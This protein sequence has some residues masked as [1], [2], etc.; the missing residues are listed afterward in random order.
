MNKEADAHEV[1]YLLAHRDGV[2]EVMIMDG[3]KAQVQ[4]EFRKKVRECGIHEKQMKPY[5]PTSNAAEVGVRKM[6][7]GVGQDQLISNSP[8]VLWG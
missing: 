5:A 6:R 2:P 7:C 3:A 8:K 1:L 4:G